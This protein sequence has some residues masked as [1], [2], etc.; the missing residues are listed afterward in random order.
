MAET[1]AQRNLYA[2]LIGIDSYESIRG[3]QGCVQDVKSMESYLSGL[4]GYTP[5]IQALTS[6][7]PLLPTKENIIQAFESHLSQAGER[8]VVL[9][10]FAGHGVRETTHIPAF[11]RVEP[12]NCL[13]TLVCYDSRVQSGPGMEGTT[14]ADK[15]IRYLLNKHIKHNEAHVLVITDCCHS[16]GNTRSMG[17]QPALTGEDPMEELSSRLA[18]PRPIPAR[19]YDGFLFHEEIPLEVL[20]PDN[21]LMEEILPQA[22]H[23]QMAACRDVEEAWEARRPNGTVGGFF[24]ITLLDILGNSPTGISYYELKERAANLMRNMKK[25]PQTPQIYSSGKNPNELYRYFLN[26]TPGE[27]PTYCTVTHNL[28]EGWTINLGAIHGIPSNAEKESVNIH[29]T[30]EEGKAYTA[31]TLSVFPGSSQIK[32]VGG[33]PKKSDVG[34]KGKVEGIGTYPLQVF[35]TGAQEGIESFLM[36]FQQ[37]SREGQNIALELVQKESLAQYVVRAQEG[38][39]YLTLPF[40]DKHLIEPAWGYEPEWASEMYNYL[41]HISQWTFFNK[42]SHLET[43][44]HRNPPQQV[45]MYPVELQIFQKMPNGEERELDTHKERLE[46]ELDSLNQYDQDCT[47]LR[48]KLTNHSDKELYCVLLYMNRLF[49][50]NPGL[51]P[52]NGIWLEPG[53]S[54]E[55][56]GGEYIEVKHYSFIEFFKWDHFLDTIKLVVSTEQFDPM[57]LYLPELPHPPESPLRNTKTRNWGI[58]DPGDSAPTKDWTTFKVE[59]FTRKP[60]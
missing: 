42:L 7:G 52:S 12:D 28:T 55:A 30:D 9:F 32:F 5:H 37:N 15:E 40:D 14:L 43:Q 19:R 22:Q 13:E 34:L 20:E 25:R 53:G 57:M 21:A 3:L 10:Y 27:R 33:A 50:S 46:L 51:L 59:I 56:I 41:I 6:P 24:T 49:T 54:I 35:L 8:D 4:S 1:T 60:Q 29:V 2:L 48:M 44:L 39:F 47:H 45:K 17:G 36:I 31:Q 23:V 18:R 16:G 11:Q 26:G 58:P 38:R